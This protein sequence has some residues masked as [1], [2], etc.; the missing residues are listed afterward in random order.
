[1]SEEKRI[2]FAPAFI[3]RM[4]VVPG[5]DSPVDEGVEDAISIAQK[6]TRHIG[7]I[8]EWKERI[9]S[10]EFLA[11]NA[12]KMAGNPTYKTV[13]PDVKLA[14]EVFNGNEDEVDFRMFMEAV[15]IVID[16]Y[17]QQAL[18]GL[19]GESD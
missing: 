11:S 8:K 3:N 1:M 5:I 14:I 13:D 16:G 15:D 4:K 10:I 17:K 9:E 7:A 6:F 2:S 12:A 19:A 18:V